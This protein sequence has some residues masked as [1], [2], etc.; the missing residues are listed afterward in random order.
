MNDQIAGRRSRFLS[1]LALVS[2]A[3]VGVACG[4]GQD[5]AP[6]GKARVLGTS[7]PWAMDDP[8]WLDEDTVVFTGFPGNVPLTP[9][10]PPPR[11]VYIWKIGGEAQVYPTRPSGR[12]VSY[13]CAER[14]RMYYDYK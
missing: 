12:E 3:A 6:P 5:P 10:Y 9:N 1:A 7:A 2:L 13:A 4:Q 8:T 11:K 14:G